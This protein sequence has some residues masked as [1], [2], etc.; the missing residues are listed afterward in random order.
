MGGTMGFG[1]RQFKRGSFPH[2]DFLKR[3]Y[4]ASSVGAN[5]ASWQKDATGRGA[6][7]VKWGKIGRMEGR[8]AGESQWLVTG[9]T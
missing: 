6:C 8:K 2:H 1:W 5:F 7:G 3:A 9:E 4:R